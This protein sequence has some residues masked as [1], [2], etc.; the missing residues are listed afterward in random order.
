M[1]WLVSSCPTPQSPPSQNKDSVIWLWRFPE[2][3]I[4]YHI[5]LDSSP[6]H[7]CRLS[8][9]CVCVGWGWGGHVGSPKWGSNPGHSVRAPKPSLCT[10]REPHTHT[11]SLPFFFSSSSSLSF[12]QSLIPYSCPASDR[13]KF[14]NFH[15]G[16]HRKCYKIKLP[17]FRSPS[18]GGLC[19][20]VFHLDGWCLAK[21]IRL[22]AH[23]N[24]IFKLASARYRNKRIRLHSLNVPSR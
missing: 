15:P 9:F 20:H 5:L 1:N 17:S 6:P 7:I 23:L 10:T 16:F 11:F 3:I 18:L 2:F 14:L 13:S 8:S 12:P 24:L 4:L 21:Y 19:W 22:P